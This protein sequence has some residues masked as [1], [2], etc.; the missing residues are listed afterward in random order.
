MK[1]G[2]KTASII[3]GAA[4]LIISVVLIIINLKGDNYDPARKHSIVYFESYDDAKT[5]L[6]Y[7]TTKLEGY[8]GGSVDSY[9][10]CDGSVIIMRAGT[11]L[12][13]ADETGILKV[14][15]AGV[16]RAVL[17]LDN[18]Y[19][20]FSTASKAF[21]YDHVDGDIIEIEGL[22]AKEIVSLAISPNSKA[23]AVSSVD[24][25]GNSMTYVYKEGKA[26]LLRSDSC[27]VA[28]GD[29]GASGYYVESFGKELTGKLYYIADKDKLIAEK[30]E[31]NFELSRDLKEITFDID[32]K[33]YYSVAGSKAKK[34]VDASVITYA[35]KSSCSMGGKY[36]SVNVKDVDSI[37]DCIHYTVYTSQ[38]VNGNLIKTYDLYYINSSHSASKLVGGTTRFV[39]G[40]SGKEIACLVDGAVY[41][42][43]AYNPKNPTLVMQNS[44]TFTCSTDLEQFY[45]V[46][47]Y[48]K[49]YSVVPGSTPVNVLDNAYFIVMGR[50]DVCL[51]I[52]DYENESGTLNWVQ[53]SETDKIASGVYSVESM[54]GATVYYA[55]GD[56]ELGVF[57]VYISSDDKSFD[58]AM[59]K[60]QLGKEE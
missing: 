48:A 31:A 2:V 12:F 46:D 58:L 25:E 24:A 41:K 34:L 39:I 7:D 1:R 27:I 37:F 8:I 13:R 5:Y 22:N 17:S 15:P 32:N 51:C 50:G 21:I 56:L 52:N 28:I 26:S 45:V 23:F 36:C 55:N 44:Y 11:G 38:D 30:A 53:G 49:L 60:I 10:T 35:G 4:V 6:F 29:D 33:T 19:I 57:D 47:N 59:E 54:N 9:L 20:L 40:K 18:R 14:Y 16:D 43:S 3:I 42:V